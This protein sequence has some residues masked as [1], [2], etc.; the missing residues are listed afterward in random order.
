[1]SETRL[2]AVDDSDQT[3]EE[4]LLFARN[5]AAEADRLHDIVD[6][7]ERQLEAESV[8]LNL[9]GANRLA[10][11][12]ARAVVRGDIGS[13]STIGDALLDFLEVGGLDGPNDVPTWIA[14][15][16]AAQAAGGDS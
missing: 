1:M 16:E 9:P 2:K 15:Y 8:R 14:K 10:Y 5:F 13:R 6:H 7:L 4:L 3:R 12:C 11:H